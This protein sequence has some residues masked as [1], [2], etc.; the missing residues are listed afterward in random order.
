LQSVTLV[1]EKKP[2]PNGSVD[3]AIEGRLELEDGGVWSEAVA[4]SR[5]QRF[6]RTVA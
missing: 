1:V 2:K 6:A 4:Q 3:C 5:K